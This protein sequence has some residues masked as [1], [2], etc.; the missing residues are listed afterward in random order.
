MTVCAGS[1]QAK[2]SGTPQAVPQD[3]VFQLLQ[4]AVYTPAQDLARQRSIQQLARMVLRLQEPPGAANII[5]VFSARYVLIQLSP[6][7]TS[8]I[9]LT[10]ILL[11]HTDFWPEAKS[12][13]HASLS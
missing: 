3:E 11:T 9:L 7:V 12:G 13:W 1:S 10:P 8:P 4:T 6:K 5:A 2:S